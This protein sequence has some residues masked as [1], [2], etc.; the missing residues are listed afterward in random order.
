MRSVTSKSLKL[1]SDIC[2]CN[3]ARFNNFD[4]SQVG[5]KLFLFSRSSPVFL[6]YFSDS[7]SL[8]LVAYSVR[9]A[10]SLKQF[11]ETPFHRF[12]NWLIEYE[13]QEGYSSK[14]EL[15]GIISDLAY[16]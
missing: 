10:E 8:W 16:T 11:M 1:S 2:V 6:Y 14:T 7:A 9:S 4:S 5:S 3:N 12:F 13:G 15:C